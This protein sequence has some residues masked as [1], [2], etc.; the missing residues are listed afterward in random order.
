MCL[1]AAVCLCETLNDVVGVFVCACV[2][3]CCLVRALFEC[4]V[5]SVVYVCFVC[6]LYRL[7]VVFDM[8]SRCFDD[9]VLSYCIVAS[10]VCL[11]IVVLM[12]FCFAL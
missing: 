8:F 5:I 10:Y 9:Y 7:L 2:L 1:C 12:F 11:D 4:L 3:Y 6:V